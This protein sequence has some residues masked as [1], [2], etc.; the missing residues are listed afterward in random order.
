MSWPPPLMSGGFLSSRLLNPNPHHCGHGLCY[1]TAKFLKKSLC[2]IIFKNSKS[3]SLL[4]FIFLVKA[5]CLETMLCIVFQI[6]CVFNKS[7]TVIDIWFTGGS[8]E[9]ISFIKSI[10]V[11]PFPLPLWPICFPCSL[12]SPPGP[13]Q[14]GVLDVLHCCF[15]NRHGRK[16]LKTIRILVTKQLKSY[17]F[18]LSMSIPEPFKDKE[19][20]TR[21]VLA[22]ST[23]VREIGSANPS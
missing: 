17:R 4:Y 3:F 14:H 9:F 6:K 18:Q 15:L 16:N 7:E 5:F 8:E 12:P 19:T 21:S 13:P 2:L 23:Q 22:S 11:L 20:F 1:F 10:K